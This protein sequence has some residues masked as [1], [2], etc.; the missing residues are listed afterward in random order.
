M[1]FDLT[2]DSTWGKALEGCNALFSS[3]LDPLIESH[4]K[5]AATLTGSAVKYGLAHRK[6]DIDDL[7]LSDLVSLMLQAHRQDLV[8]R[9]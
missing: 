4:M 3:S 9:C 7:P 6:A 8:L 5:F 2:D 1:D